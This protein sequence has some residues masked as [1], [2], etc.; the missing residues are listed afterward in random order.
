MSKSDSLVFYYYLSQLISTKSNSITNLNKATIL[1]L[2]DELGYNCFHWSCGHKDYDTLRY[3]LQ[4]GA[5]PNSQTTIE[6]LTGLHLAVIPEKCIY[7][8]PIDIYSIINNSHDSFDYNTL[9][10]VKLLLQ[11]GAK[12]NISDIMGISPLLFYYLMPYSTSKSDSITNLVNCLAELNTDDILNIKLYSPSGYVNFVQCSTL[13]RSVLAVGIKHGKVSRTSLHFQMDEAETITSIL[14]NWN[15]LFF[16]S[17][18]IRWSI[19]FPQPNPLLLMYLHNWISVYSTHDTCQMK[20]LLL[21]Y[22]CDVIK[23]FQQYPSAIH[24]LKSF[25]LYNIL[26]F[27]W[28]Q[29]NELLVTHDTC[30]ILDFIIRA[31]KTKLV[32][33]INEIYFDLTK[34]LYP[35]LALLNF[36]YQNILNDTVNDLIW[37]NTQLLEIFSLL[38]NL[39]ETRALNILKIITYDNYIYGKPQDMLLF[40]LQYDCDCNIKERSSNQTIVGLLADKVSDYINFRGKSGMLFE[41]SNDLKLIA[42]LLENGAYPLILE[43]RSTKT[44]M[45][46]LNSIANKFPEFVEANSKSFEKIKLSKYYSKPFPLLS[47]CAMKIARCKINIVYMPTENKLLSS[48]LIN[49]IKLHKLY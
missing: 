23:S 25:H 47:L 18:S 16:Y 17:N 13:Q 9:V 46:V 8:Y 40:L 7:Q 10:I 6:K 19:L 22:I 24:L 27:L 49:F 41:E 1:E 36:F 3:V 5:N 26:E 12:V 39:C 31:F 2:K 33:C 42:L 11:Y 28:N 14:K 43:S 48:K 15:Y 44:A 20:D 30:T 34:R 29:R 21:D 37:P 32:L 35:G 4:L 38:Q 45:Y